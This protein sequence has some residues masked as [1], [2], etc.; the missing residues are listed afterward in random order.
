MS[1]QRRIL[2]K[3]RACKWCGNSFQATTPNARYCSI[4]CRDKAYRKRRAE[5]ASRLYYRTQGKM[6]LLS[7]MADWLVSAYD[8]GVM[9]DLYDCDWDVDYICRIIEYYKKLY[10]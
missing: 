5:Y 8:I 1:E 9:D 7:E 2:P 6:E 3:E 10:M 4:E